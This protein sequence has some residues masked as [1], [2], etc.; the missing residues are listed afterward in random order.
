MSLITAKRGTGSLEL[1]QRDRPT[2]TSMLAGVRNADHLDAVLE[3]GQPVTATPN[4]RAMLARMNIKSVGSDAMATAMEDAGITRDWREAFLT[5]THLA[6]HDRPLLA[7]LLGKAYACSTCDWEEDCEAVLRNMEEAKGHWASLTEARQQV[8]RHSFNERTYEADA[9]AYMTAVYMTGER[10][11]V[12]NRSME[13]ISVSTNPGAG[14]GFIEKL[15]SE[16][17]GLR[18][19]QKQAELVDDVTY[20][21]YDP[22]QMT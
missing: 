21:Y 11:E 18:V 2:F 12:P 19:P 20:E 4:A 15:I 9:S 7:L 14:T 22:L 5:D 10:I 1:H 6:A 8:Q 17:R 13:G 3:L 16:A